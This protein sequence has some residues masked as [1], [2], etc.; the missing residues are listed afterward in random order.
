MIKL[1]D[2]LNEVKVSTYVNIIKDLIKS[3]DW[4]DFK[5][6]IEVKNSSLDL[7][8]NIENIGEYEEENAQNELIRLKE[9]CK[10]F[11]Y[12]LQNLVN[13]QEN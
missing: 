2:L 9:Q 1:N 5:E 3:I 12:V 4:I 10:D 11:I 6:F 8:S 13:N 7:L